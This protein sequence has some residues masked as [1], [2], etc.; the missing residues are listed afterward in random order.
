MGGSRAIIYNSSV[1]A[2]TTAWQP[3]TDSDLIAVSSTGKI[4]VSANPALTV[5][6]FESGSSDQS[7]IAYS[8]SAQFQNFGIVFPVFTAEKYYVAFSAAGSAIFY[9]TDN[10]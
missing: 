1:G 9:L 2:N 4:V 7:V 5:A 6:A 10:S 3:A 8:P